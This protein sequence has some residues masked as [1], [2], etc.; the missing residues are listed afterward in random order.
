MPP[1]Q[2]GPPHYPIENRNL[3]AKQEN[4]SQQT[5]ASS[6]LPPLGFSMQVTPGRWNAPDF[7]LQQMAFQGT[8]IGCPKTQLNADTNW[9]Y[10]RPCRF[11][12]QSHETPSASNANQGCDLYFWL[13]GYISEVPMILRFGSLICWGG[14]L[15]QTNILFMFIYCK[16]YRETARWRHLPYKMCEGLRDFCLFYAGHRLNTSCI[17]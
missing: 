1:F 5:K 2:W 8:P 15:T 9:S 13:A 4:N 11:L 16:G 12:I 10:C 3:Q 14:S 6:W 7:P 17:Q